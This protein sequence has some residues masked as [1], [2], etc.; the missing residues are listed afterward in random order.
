[1]LPIF[2]VGDETLIKYILIFIRG[3]NAETNIE[4]F[5]QATCLQCITTAPTMRNVSLCRIY[6]CNKK[7]PLPLWTKTENFG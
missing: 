6:E 7:N 5:R 1:M 4:P 3:K 2:F